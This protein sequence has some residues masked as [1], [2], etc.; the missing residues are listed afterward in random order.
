MRRTPLT[1]HARPASEYEVTDVCAGEGVGLFAWSPLK[2][3]WLSGKVRRDPAEAA[4]SL[5]GSRI[6]WAEGESRSDQACSRST[7]ADAIAPPPC[8]WPA[9]QVKLQS[10]PTLATFKDDERVWALLKEME[11]IAAAH[12]G[13]ATV[14][15]VRAGPRG[16]G[17]HA[18]ADSG[19][20]PLLCEVQVA[21]R[22]LLQRRTVAG[23]VLGVKTVAQLRDNLGALSFE[24][25]PSEVSRLDELSSPAAIY[26]YEMVWRVNAARNRPGTTTGGAALAAG[27]K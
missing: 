21:L 23:V 24:L 7:H 4:V 17:S 3:G 18:E 11:G 1:F 10:A 26:P 2:G 20:G 14:A 15:Q 6:E 19:T 8:H 22:W 5:A 12:G 16:S 27:A 25:S 9:N 13:G